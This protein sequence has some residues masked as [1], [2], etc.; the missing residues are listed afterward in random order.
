MHPSDPKELPNKTILGSSITG[1]RSEV[2]L[3]LGLAHVQD[4]ACQPPYI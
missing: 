2:G 3:G 1:L 4:F